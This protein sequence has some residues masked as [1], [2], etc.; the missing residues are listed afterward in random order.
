MKL[1]FEIILSLKQTAT[2]LKR[3]GIIKDLSDL[4]TVIGPGLLN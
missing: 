2:F 1:D 4:S 3:Q